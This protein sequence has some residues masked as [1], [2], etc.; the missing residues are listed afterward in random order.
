VRRPISTVLLAVVLLS[1]CGDGAGGGGGGGADADVA[2]LPDLPDPTGAQPC[3]VP[4]VLCVD[5]SAVEG[6]DGSAEQPF[7]SIGDAVAAGGAGAVVQVAAG[8][9]EEAVLV[10]QVDGLT[11][12]GGFAAGGDFTDRDPG[13][14][15]TVVRGDAEHAVVTVVASNGIRIE[16]FRL[17]GG[18]GFDDGFN[19]EGGGVYVDGESSGVAIVANQIVGNAVDHGPQPD[20]TRGGGIS[21]L[22]TDIEIIGNVVEANRGGRG[23]GIAVTGGATIDGNRVLDNHAVGDH[24]GGLWL[25]G[26]LTV[27]RNHVE[28]NTIG[29]DVGYGWGGG[30]IVFGAE[31]DATLQGNVV[32]GN[33][34]V[35]HGSG[36]FIDDGAHATI[37]GDLY[38]A[39]RCPQEGGAGLFVDSGG[40]RATTVEVR[41]VTIAEHDCPDVAQGGNGVYVGRSD[42]STEDQPVVTVADSILWHNAPSD[43]FVADARLTITGTLTEAPVDGEG[44]ATGDPRFADPAGGDFTPDPSGPGAGRGAT[45]A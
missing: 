34:A 38:H 21:T 16:G 37:T 26:P 13:A 19:V 30:I 27:T 23:A 29:T 22:G 32:T 10:D 15:P 12:L 31:A 5:A 17:T 18:G 2:P 39:N 41:N 8:D 24:G 1:A 20:N 9:Y 33:L 40:G 43:T 11:L 36:V 28:G 25:T 35:S 44:N 3:D 14:N 4:T 45:S 42:A 7:R 6:G